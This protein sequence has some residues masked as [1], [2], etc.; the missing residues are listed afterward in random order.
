MSAQ[1]IEPELPLYAK[2]IIIYA[3]VATLYIIYLRSLPPNVEVINKN[4]NP[5]VPIAVDS[6][7]I[8]SVTTITS[9]GLPNATQP[10]AT[11]STMSQSPS[12]IERITS[13]FSSTN[14]VNVK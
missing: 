12:F 5:S 10:L 9:G 3:I 13:F 14:T 8:A 11:T 4:T 7:R 2:V 1:I 6:N